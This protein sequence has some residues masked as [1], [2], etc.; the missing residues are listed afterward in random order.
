MRRG[1]KRHLVAGQRGNEPSDSPCW[2]HQGERA[3]E[4]VDRWRLGDQQG[5]KVGR[6]DRH[7]PGMM[8]PERIATRCQQV[9]CS[10]DHHV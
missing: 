9:W 6:S 2:A 10:A 5:E 3:A 8:R 1:S 7:R 4:H